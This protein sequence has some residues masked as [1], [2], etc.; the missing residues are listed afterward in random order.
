M[1]KGLVLV[2]LIAGNLLVS[3]TVAGQI[4]TSMETS[5]LLANPRLSPEARQAIQDRVDV[6]HARFRAVHGGLGPEQFG[7][8]C[9]QIT[10]IHAF[11]FTPLYQGDWQAIGANDYMRPTA[12]PNELAAPVP[13]PSGVEIVFLDL[14]FYDVH[15]NWDISARLLAYSGGGVS[16]GSP[17]DTTLASATSSGTPGFGYASS[18]AFSHTVNNNVGYDP[19]AAQ[20]AVLIW[21]GGATTAE[22]GFKAVD[23]WWMRQVSP[24]PATASFSDV[25]TSHPYFQFVEAL[26]AAGITGGCGGSPPLYC[27]DAPITRGQMAVF[28]SK[29]LGLYWPH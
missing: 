10:Q 25:P 8:Q 17:T 29:A 24:P 27:V 6:V 26:A 15:S 28:L 23:L 13:F 11:A 3:T 16:S 7:V 19:A 9:C 22:V 5:S 12:L 14:Y 1:A 20:L 4:A 21:A 2:L 18:P